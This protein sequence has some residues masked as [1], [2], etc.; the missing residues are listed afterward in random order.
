MGQYL[1]EQ[2]P[3]A[4]DPLAE[5]TDGDDVGSPSEFEFTQGELPVELMQSAHLHHSTQCLAHQSGENT[6][7]IHEG[8]MQLQLHPVSCGVGN[9]IYNVLNITASRG[10]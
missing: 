1:K 10:Q 6:S 8:D 4:V 7:E 5:T 3:V 9:T 2:G